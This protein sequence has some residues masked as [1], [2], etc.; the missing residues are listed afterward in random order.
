TMIPAGTKNPNRRMSFTAIIF[1]VIRQVTKTEAMTTNQN[2]TFKR[3]AP[4]AEFTILSTRETTTSIM[5]HAGSESV[6]FA[7]LSFRL[8]GRGYEHGLYHGR[9]RA[10][11]TSCVSLYGNSLPQSVALARFL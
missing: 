11:V 4:F 9:V 2:D 3:N 1:A 6:L 10:G 5:P 8:A 7:S